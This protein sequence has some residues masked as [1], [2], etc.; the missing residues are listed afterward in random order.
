MILNEIKYENIVHREY[1]NVESHFHLSYLNHYDLPV[2]T[3][4][5][6]QRPT[7][8]CAEKQTATRDS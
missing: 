7:V 5:N 4:E 6:A 8:A 1:L 2:V 3:P